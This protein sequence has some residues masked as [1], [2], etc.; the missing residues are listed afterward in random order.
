MQQSRELIFVYNAD[1]SLFAAVSDFVH[2]MISPDTYSCNLCKITYGTIRMKSQW[3]EF[4]EDLP[5]S[6]TF[7]HKDE[8]HKKY[9]E[10]K[11]TTLPAVFLKHDKMIKICISAKKLNQQK[12]IDDLKALVLLQLGKVSIGK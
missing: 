6:V 4:I 1:S 12:T 7:L 11:N 8:F 2:K 10:F 5:I 9:P 3:K